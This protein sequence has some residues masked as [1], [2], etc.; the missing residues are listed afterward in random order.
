MG[1]N[2]ERTASIIF[3][4]NESNALEFIRHDED[5]RSFIDVLLDPSALISEDFLKA[6]GIS[7]TSIA[8]LRRFCREDGFLGSIELPVHQRHISVSFMCLMLSRECLTI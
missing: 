2:S 5:A 3:L 8:L 6:C 7:E 1:L 4:E